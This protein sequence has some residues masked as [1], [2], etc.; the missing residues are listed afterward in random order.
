MD[1]KYT[2]YALIF[3][4]LNVLIHP[5]MKIKSTAAAWLWF[6]HETYPFQQNTVTYDIDQQLRL[7][8]Y[9]HVIT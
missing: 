8:V 1:Y 9:M 5:D 6:E 3:I 4:T 2:S 7:L